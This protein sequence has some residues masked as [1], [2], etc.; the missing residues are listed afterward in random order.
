MTVWMDKSGRWFATDDEGAQHTLAAENR[1]DAYREA[2][3]RLGGKPEKLVVLEP[4]EET[5]RKKGGRPKK[6][7]PPP[8]QPP[9]VKE[10]EAG[11]SEAVPP[12][13]D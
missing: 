6:S 10:E 11:A 12:I 2:T 1:A 9:P 3:T 5:P 4:E 7:P 13:P 8:P